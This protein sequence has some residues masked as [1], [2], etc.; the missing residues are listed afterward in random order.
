MSIRSKPYWPWGLCVLLVILT[1]ALALSFQRQRQELQLLRERLQ[2]FQ[3][4]QV[5]LETLR[6]QNER[7]RSF[8]DASSSANVP[9][10]TT[11]ELMRLRHELT[12]LQKLQSELEALREANARLLQAIQNTPDLSPTQMAHIVEAR[13]QGSILGVYIQPAPPGQSGVLVG[14]IDPRAPAARSGLLP[15]DLIY[16]L[17][18]KPV[19]TAGALQAEMLSRSPGQVVVIDVLRTNTPLRFQVQTWAWPDG[20]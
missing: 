17:D 13:K 9:E 10:E 6:L 20:R 12:R 2:Q 14:G 19:A 7:S 8:L 18:G 5:E 15:G 16:A 1:A 3:E 11:R 4:L